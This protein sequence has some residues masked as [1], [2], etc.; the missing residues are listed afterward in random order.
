MDLNARVDINCGRKEG[1]TDGWTKNRMPISHLAKAGATKMSKF[2]WSGMIFFFVQKTGYRL[3]LII[4]FKI[5]CL[6]PDFSLTFYSFPYPL[7]D[8]KTNHFYSLL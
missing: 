8:P 4:H 2:V 3:P 5:P 1:R 7:I 6:F